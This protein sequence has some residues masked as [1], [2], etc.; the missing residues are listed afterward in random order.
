MSVRLN[1]S[2][3]ESIV[4]RVLAVAFDDKFKEVTAR[5]V[6]QFPKFRATLLGKHAKAYDSLPDSWKR[7]G[8]FSTFTL[9]FDRTHHTVPLPEATSLPEHFSVEAVRRKT[10]EMSVRLKNRW[11]SHDLKK[12]YEDA[13]AALE[14]L[15]APLEELAQLIVEREVMEEEVES[16]VNSVST[17]K[18]LYEVWPELVEIVPPSENPARGTA[19]AVD[20]DKLN[21]KIPLPQEKK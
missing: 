12:Q 1:K 19:M 6:K 4:H 17:E 7:S 13:D 20:V 15:R 16:V 14:V 11:R 8:M 2:S 18:R 9:T 5:V 21:A 10:G 3:R